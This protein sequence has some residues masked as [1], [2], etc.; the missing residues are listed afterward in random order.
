MLDPTEL[1]VLIDQVLNG[2]REAFQRIVREFSLPLRSYLAAQVYHLDDVDDLAQDV[3]IAAY[4]SLS[5]FRRGDDFGAWLRGI[6]RNKLYGHLRSK[7][8]RERTLAR[9]REEVARAVESDLE[10]AASEDDRGTIEILL[11]CIS[12]LPEKMRRVVRAG[13]DGDKPSVL[14]EEL[15]TSVGAIYNLHYRANKRLREC[16]RKE[17]S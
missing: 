8:R 5:T 3:L 1:Q 7:A 12:R 6:A 11:H 17:L 10:R 9:L 14:A 2:K 13:L 15:V 4:R 16:L